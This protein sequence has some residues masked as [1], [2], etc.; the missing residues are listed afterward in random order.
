MNF[1]LCGLSFLSPLFSWFVVR[2]ACDCDRYM[3]MCITAYTTGG[4]PF[5]GRLSYYRDNY[6]YINFVSVEFLCYLTC[7]DSKL[8]WYSVTMISS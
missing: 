8:I 7:V 6:M 3:Y 2:Y 1:I 5:C 4:V